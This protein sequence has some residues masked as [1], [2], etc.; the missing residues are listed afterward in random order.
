MLCA[1]ILVSVVSVSWFQVQVLYIVQDSFPFIF[2]P[3]QN[4][5]WDFNNVHFHLRSCE[6]LRAECAVGSGMV[7]HNVSC[8]VLQSCLVEE[9]G[10]IF[11]FSKI[12]FKFLLS[13]QII[14]P[15]FFHVHVLVDFVG[16]SWKM[17]IGSP[18]SRGTY[19]SLQNYIGR[20]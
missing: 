9:C 20:T 16:R 11:L 10:A 18:S 5:L 19:K 17:L 6:K 14:E 7:F 1:Q 3:Y 15:S 4:P 13:G 12:L 8:T 2:H